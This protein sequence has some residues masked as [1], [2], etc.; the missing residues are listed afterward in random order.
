MRI[1]IPPNA[2]T[3]ELMKLL[4]IER[5]FD[6]D[7]EFTGEDLKDWIEKLKHPVFI[8][9]IKA[10]LGFTLSM[11]DTAISFAQRLLA[12]LGLNLTFV[13]HRRRGDGSRQRVYRG[14]D[15]FADGRG[16]VFDYWLE[17]DRE[18]VKPAAFAA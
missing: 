7:Q 15:P 11:G 17:R 13:S 3:V 1:S 9:Q 10:V 5:F 12:K 8:S 18:S 2:V 16:E 14:C 6:S 4:G